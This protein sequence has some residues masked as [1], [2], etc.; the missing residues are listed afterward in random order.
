VTGDAVARLRSLSSS[1]IADATGGRGALRPGLIRLSGTGTV[2][3]RAVTAECAEGSLR[4]V[5]PALDDAQSGDILCMTAPGD[6]AYMGDLLAHDITNRGLAG[7]VVDGLIRDRDAIAALAPS[8]YARGVT[9]VARRGQ[10]PGRSQVP[11]EIGGVVVNPGD[12]IVGDGD[13]VVVI[14]S[15]QLDAVLAQAEDD[16]QT[17]ARIMARVQSGASVMDAVTAELGG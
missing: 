17:E 2:A 16:L 6:T 1:V 12:W 5:F 7:A 14:P 10:D 11:I 15:A 8:F 3:G 13:G 4:A 9:P